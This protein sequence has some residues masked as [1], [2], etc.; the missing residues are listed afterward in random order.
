[1]DSLLKDD[2]WCEMAAH[3]GWDEPATDE[4]AEI[5][6]ATQQCE[7]A[8][9]AVAVP[10]I[11]LGETVR[12]VTPDSKLAGYAGR[13]VGLLADGRIVVA[14]AHLSMADRASYPFAEDEVERLAQA[15]AVEAA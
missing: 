8:A 13:V 3:F 1:M 15:V 2:V 14:F 7:L 6:Y 4:Q 12:V 11:E 9:L 5:D 10:A